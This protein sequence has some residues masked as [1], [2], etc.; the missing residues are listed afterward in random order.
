M[1]P[2]IIA[3]STLAFKTSIPLL[4]GVGLFSYHGR[5]SS[6]EAGW[7]PVQNLDGVPEAA[8]SPQKGG[9][10]L[11]LVPHKVAQRG[12]HSAGGGRRE[13]GLSYAFDSP[14]MEEQ[15]ANTAHALSCIWGAKC[16]HTSA[17]RSLVNE[18]GSCGGGTCSEICVQRWSQR[19]LAKGIHATKR[20]LFFLNLLYSS[21]ECAF[22]V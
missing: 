11:Q 16:P 6:K 13:A 20:L 10:R 15:L 12:P 1:S 17:R 14:H 22:V 8:D 19:N 4:C 7:C 3:K 5:S 21:C 9:Y 18:G 2:C